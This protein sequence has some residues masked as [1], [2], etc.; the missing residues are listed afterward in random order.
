M[1]RNVGMAA[2]LTVAVV[3]PVHEVV[4]QD[5][6]GGALLGGA[7]GAVV[8]G[9]V[10]GGRG[11]GIGAITRTGAGQNFG[12]LFL[13][14]SSLLGEAAARSVISWNFRPYGALRVDGVVTGG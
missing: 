5:I 8:G 11:A 6:L 10:G 12:G 14:V 1:I 4:A 9:A 2:L 13:P 3:M 7:A